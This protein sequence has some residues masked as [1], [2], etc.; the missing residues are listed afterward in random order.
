MPRVMRI[1]PHPGRMLRIRPLP[2]PRLPAAVP[3]TRLSC[4]LCSLCLCGQALSLLSAAGYKLTASLAFPPEPVQ[5]E[6][7]VKHGY[8]NPALV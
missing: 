5:A 8:A 6:M 2:R 7:P 4:S 3:T 1:I